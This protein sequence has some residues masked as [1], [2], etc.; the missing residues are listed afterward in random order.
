[1][2]VLYSRSKLSSYGHSRTWI[3]CQSLRIMKPSANCHDSHASSAMSDLLVLDCRWLAARR[4][5]AWLAKAL[6]LLDD[7]VTI[8]P[9]SSDLLPL[10]HHL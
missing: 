4:L 2:Y 3:V 7:S 5:P 9:R 1:M 6:W 8:F 10:G